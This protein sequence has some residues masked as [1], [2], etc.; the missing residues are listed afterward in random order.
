[1]LSQV[2]CR[3]KAKVKESLVDPAISV[4][5]EGFEESLT[6]LV[7]PASFSACIILSHRGFQTYLRNELWKSLTIFPA[8]I[9]E[10]LRAVC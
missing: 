9:L 3:N 5:D 2:L 6:D 4:E 7:M 8:I 1:M 10:A